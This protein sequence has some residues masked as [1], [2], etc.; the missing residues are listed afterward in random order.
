VTVV[1]AARQAL[2]RDRA[3]LAAGARLQHPKEREPNRLLQ[4]RIALELD[5]GPVP[6]GV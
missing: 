3:A 6:E 1:A 4:L 5:V 2:G